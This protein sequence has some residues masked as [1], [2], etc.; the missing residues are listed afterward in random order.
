MPIDI[1]LTIMVTSVV[2]SIFGVGVLLF[3]TPLLLLQGY[4][5]VDALG[6][7]LPVSIS[8]SVLQILKH[9][10][11][12]DNDFF[13]QVLRY[14]VPVVVLFLVLITSIKINVGLI[15]GVFLLL[16]ALK[17]FSKTIEH[18]LQAIVKYE[19]TYLIITGI[20]HGVSNLG[21]SLLTVMIYSKHYPKNT[22]RVTAAACYATLAGFQL[23][24]LLLMGSE[25]SISYPV[26]ASLVQVGIFM[27]LFIEE[28]L[29]GHIDNEKYSKIFAAFL[30]AAGW[31]LIA[32]AL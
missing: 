19:K 10:E 12:I 15:I 2:Q 1:L 14:S 7:V 28:T 8:I 27:F 30:F 3:G 17:G 25:F 18:A 23:L 31:A 4:S 21:G 5:F 32:K 13:N 16:V 29:Y 26:K 24:T 9:N 20:V 22:T 11:H 6:I